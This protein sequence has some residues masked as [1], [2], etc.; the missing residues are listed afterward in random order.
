MT[1]TVNVNVKGVKELNTEISNILYSNTNSIVLSNNEDLNTILTPG[2]YIL[3]G[4]GFINKP[5]MCVDEISVLIVEA[6]S[7]EG[8]EYYLQRVISSDTVYTRQI[9]IENGVSNISKWKY[10]GTEEVSIG[11]E[12]VIPHSL[13]GDIPF[14]VIGRN[15]DA[16]NSVTL[17]SKEIIRLLAFDAKESSNTNTSRQKYGNNRYK[18]SNILQWMNSDKAGGQWYTAQHSVDAAPDSTNVVSHNPYSNIDG[19]LKGFSS[20]VVNSMITVDKTTVLHPVDGGGSE[21]VS[22]KVFLLSTTEVGIN[23][24]NIAEGKIYEYFS[25]NNVDSQRLAYPSTYCLNNA[26]GFTSTGLVSGKPWH[27]WLRT[28]SSVNSDIVRSVDISGALNNNYAYIGSYG[29]RL[30]LSLKTM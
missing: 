6:F 17:L 22:S 15:H 30:A 28:P 10:N 12:I 25:N 16:D 14:I 11:D 1:G 9:C 7:I 29:L 13:Y 18:Y 21:V 5:I 8:K 2:K 3:F 20:D 23:E 4:N 26:G 24:N 19:F 27:W